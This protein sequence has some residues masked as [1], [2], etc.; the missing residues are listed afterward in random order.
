M[1]SKL[2]ELITSPDASTRNTALD[3]VRE[4]QAACQDLDAFRRHSNNLY[5]RVRSLFFLYAIHRFHLPSR[6]ELPREGSIPIEGFHRFLR[7]RFD[8]AIQRFLAEQ[9]A[10]GP[11]DT[12]CSALAA[13]YRGLAAR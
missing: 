10:H 12:L 1:T 3:A 2:Q 7:R 6:P 5:E 8:E 11:S 9:K 13:A 4:L